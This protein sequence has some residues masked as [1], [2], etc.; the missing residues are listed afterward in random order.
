VGF[1]WCFLLDALS[2]VAVLACLVMMRASE[3]F[4][5]PPKARTGREVR[6]GF[7]YVLSVPALWV[8]FVMFA[9]IGLFSFNLRV[10]LPLLVMGP[11]HG[12][13][14]A[15]ASIYATSSFGAVL[16][17][18]V[19]AHR[20]L[21]RLRHVVTGALVFGC[22]M[23]LL[24]VV[25]SVRLAVPAA[26]LVGGAGI[27]YMTATTTI[28]QVDIRRDMHGRVLALQTALIGATALLGGPLVGQ[29]ADLAGG[30][31]PIAV[32]G[33]VCLAAACFGELARRRFP[34]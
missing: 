25:P 32:G 34:G 5:Q 4:R 29:L 9:C 8:S 33:G 11:L 1:G 31:A 28:A 6:E 18:L 20:R 22:A 12:S 23:L 19:V 17:T 21:V 13:E 7:A 15:F 3:L 16:G 10:A 30:R 27:V 26:F 2:Y 14:A 24:A